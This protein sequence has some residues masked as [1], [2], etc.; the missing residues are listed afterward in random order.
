MPAM[1]LS[2]K[3][4]VG[5]G[6]AVVAFIAVL[7]AIPVF[8][9]DRITEVLKTQVNNSIDAHVGW[10]DVGLSLLRNFPHAS[11]TATDLSVA[12][13][14]TFEHDTLFATRQLRFVLDVRSVIGYL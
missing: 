2:Q 5:V 14:R 8:F 10:H 6:V 3:I 12:G 9:G 13:V 1:R 7:A 4:G 11:L